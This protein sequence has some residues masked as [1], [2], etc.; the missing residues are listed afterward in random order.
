MCDSEDPRVW[1]ETTVTAR[2]EHRCDDCGH[3]VVKGEKYLTISACYSEG[4]ENFKLHTECMVWRRAYAAWAKVYWGDDCGPPMCRLVEFLWEA[5][6]EFH[7]RAPK[8]PSLY[9][10]EAA[11]G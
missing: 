10:V 8:K 11:H 2:K 3:A 7:V 9:L 5:H 6:H 4:W 1:E